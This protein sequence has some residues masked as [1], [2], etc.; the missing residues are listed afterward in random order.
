MR[1]G[2][3]IDLKEF[4]SI[5]IKRFWVI[6]LCAVIVGTSVLVYTVNFVTPMYGASVAIYVNNNSR[7]DSSTISSSD[8]AVALRLVA[9][10]VNII[11][12]D[13]VL[14]KVIAES[15]MPI[16][17]KQLRG[18]ISANPIGETEM[19]RVSVLSP[20]P[21][22]SATLANAIAKVAPAEI[23]DIIEGSSAKIIDHA[24]VPTAPSSPDY[25]KSAAY[26]VLAGA[27]I[28]VVCLF[29]QM[30]L[31]FRVKTE[32]DLA[33]ICAIPVLGVIPDFSD[34]TQKRSE[35]RKRR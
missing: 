14:E 35:N 3:E 7:K 1:E 31:D 19:F 18:M 20:N 16:T 11:Q 4:F 12:S 32:E 9:T 13:R 10:Y 5:L 26:G 29:L 6:L 28:A 24:K 8:L 17:V 15:G 22:L 2:F 21:E 27:F 25:L 34:E 33:K 30:L 23:S